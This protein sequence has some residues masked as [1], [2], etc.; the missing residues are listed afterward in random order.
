MRVG[1]REIGPSEPTFFIA[2]IGANHDGQLERALKLISLAAEAGADAVKFQHFRAEHIVSDRG[3]RELGEQKSHQSRWKDTVYRIYEAASLP[4]AWTSKLA[5]R[6]A[7]DGVTFLT[8]PYDL[9]A[10]ETVEP[11]VPA[12]K[13]GS[14]DITWLEAI[15]Q[16]A[17]KG[18][19]VFLATGASTLEEVDAAVHVLRARGAAFAV[20]QCNTNYTGTPENLAHTNLLVLN[21]YATRYPDAVLGLSDHTHGNVTTLG[22]VALGARV[23]EK[24]FT[25]DVDREGPDHSF[26]MVPETWSAMVSETRALELALG[27]SSKNVAQN[28][29]ETVVVQRRSIRFAQALAAGDLIGPEDLVLLRPAPPGSMGPQL[30]EDVIGQRLRKSVGRHELVTPNLF[31]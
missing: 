25:D 23:I 21:T 8:S 14:G 27:S 6:A 7:A 2:D 15:D 28:E 5:Q 13:V 19:P 20:M 4:W 9:E 30:I 26:A 12:Y 10:I 31:R 22:A 11:Y 29:L 18:K 24:H 1:D 16:M 17:Q 3:F